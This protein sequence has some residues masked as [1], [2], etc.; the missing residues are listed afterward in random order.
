M[1]RC[2]TSAGAGSA[3]L[4]LPFQ[5]FANFRRL[6]MNRFISFRK[7][8]VVL[9][10]LGVLSLSSRLMAAQEVP[11]HIEGTFTFDV[12]GNKVDASGSGRATPG[13]S[14][15]FHDVVKAE[16]GGREIA[17]TLTF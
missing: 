14:F 5:C 17:G 9:V 6:L 11:F 2:A 4:R 13:G 10:G 1:R 7:L 3:R 16:Y 12:K 15:V 8:V